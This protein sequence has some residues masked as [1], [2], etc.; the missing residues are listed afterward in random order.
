VLVDPSVA[1]IVRAAGGDTRPRP[2][3]YDV[4]IV[5]AG[6]AGLTAA[7]YG[8]SEGL[9]TLLLEREAVGGQAGTSSLIRNYLGFP[10]GVS[11]RELAARASEQAWL[12]GANFVFNAATSLHA[13]GPHRV[14]TLADG[15]QATSRAVVLA[16]GVSYR[17][18]D[19]PG[20]D[21]LSGAGVFYGAGVAETAAMKGQEV[22]VVGGGN[23][24]GQAA[25]HLA[26]NAAQVT[27]LARGQSLAATMSDYLVREI[28][29][30]ANLTVRLHTQ[31][32]AVHG[33]GQLEGLT[34][35]NLSGGP[36]ADVPAAALFI[37]IGAEPHTDWLANTLARDSRG[38]ILTDRD[39]LQEDKPVHQWPLDRPPFLLE[40]SM[41]GVFAVGDVR[42]RSVK[43]VA[44]AVGD[45]SITI[46]LIHEYL[47][48]Q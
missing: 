27:I 31:I 34:L 24:A 44:S 2:G 42:Y 3:V 40:A 16:T 8:A 43:R 13:S 20:L 7:T 32:A 17:R 36:P 12:F 48:D 47:S 33:T 11:G 35:D 29:Q 10:R 5:G 46:Q 22:F 23:S 39:L 19:I 26:K 28:R 38:F 15:S 41:P 30:S 37:L 6:P 9:R 45:G 18:L 1:E 4:T 14:L 21:E 25:L